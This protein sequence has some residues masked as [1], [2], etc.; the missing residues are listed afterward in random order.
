MA[1]CAR[2]EA[3]RQG[4]DALSRACTRA[5]HLLALLLL[6]ALA[7]PRALAGISANDDTRAALVAEIE[8]ALADPQLSGGIQAVIVESLDDG[9]VWYERSPRMLML[10]ASNQ[11]LLTTAAAIQL[12]GR[13]FRYRTSALIRSGTLR[14]GVVHGN[15]CLRGSGDPFL[16]D[17]GLDEMV[18]AIKARGVRRVSGAIVADADL[19]APPRYGFGWSWDD[20]SYYYSAPVSALNL[21]RNLV[22]VHVSPG[23]AV[24][25]PAIVRVTPSAAGAGVVN[26]ARTAARGVRS[27]IVV[28]RGLGKDVVVVEGNLAVDAGTQEQKP[29]DVTVESPPGYSVRVLAAKLRRAG[30]GVGEAAEV[31]SRPQAKLTEVAAHV[32]PPLADMI[33]RVNKPSDNLG[34]ECLLRTIGAARGGA[35]SVQNGREAVLEWLKQIGADTNGVLMRDGSGLSRMNYVT[36]DCIRV[37]LRHMYR[38]PDGEAFRASLPVAGVDGTLRNRM[39][40]SAAAGNCRAKTGYVSNVSSL[41]GY[42]TAASGEHLLFVMLMNNHP[43]RNAAATAVQDRIVRALAEH[44]SRVRP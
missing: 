24:G 25:M 40:G 30:I 28:E 32:S 10:P 44:D 37:V 21:N 39:K 41:S 36:A 42:V 29:I 5:A 13:S 8:A 26:R 2:H 27:S 20:M 31:R 19:F 9:A 18:R 23:R 15:L 1:R 12:L 22:Q 43:C 33:A 4:S 6:V 14:G 38:H 3:V 34:A 16:D 7:C 35:G 17:A 11:K